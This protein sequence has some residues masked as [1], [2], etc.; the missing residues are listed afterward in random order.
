METGVIKM[1]NGENWETWNFRLWIENNEALSNY[2]KCL[3]IK[4][5]EDVKLNEYFGS[6]PDQRL[7]A[8]LTQY[9]LEL[10]EKETKKMECGFLSD[11]LNRSISLVNFNDIAKYYI[12]QIKEEKKAQELLTVE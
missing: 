11:V 6:A 4:Y 8:D 5:T 12:W 9:A 2:F 10:V 1:T 3:Y 7:V